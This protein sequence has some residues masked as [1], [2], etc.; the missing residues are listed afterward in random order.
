MQ[1]TKLVVL[2]KDILAFEGKKG[3]TSNPII[4]GQSGL[5][6]EIHLFSQGGG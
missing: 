1:R 2:L 3:Q 5:P 6:P 4:T